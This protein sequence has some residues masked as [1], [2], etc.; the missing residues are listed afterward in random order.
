MSDDEPQALDLIIAQVQRI[1]P[2]SNH[3][4]APFIVPPEADAAI[5]IDGFTGRFG[6]IMVQR[7]KEQ[8]VRAW[9]GRC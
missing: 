3:F 4:G 9:N 1:C 7:C 2:V 5:V 6:Y 8:P